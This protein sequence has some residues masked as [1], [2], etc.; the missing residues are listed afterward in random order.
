MNNTAFAIPLAYPDTVVMVS[1]EWCIRNLHYIGVGKRNYVK[2]GHAA[3]VLIE[4][5]TGYIEYFDFGRYITPQ[6]FGRV[7]SEYTDHELKTPIKAEIV[8]GVLM[9]RDA[10]FK[11]FATHPKLTHGEGRM[12]TT[13][14]DEVDYQ[15][16]KTY[17][18]KLQ[19]KGLVNYAAFKK[20]ASNCARFV[21]D[22]LMASTE[23][24]IKLKKLKG[25]KLFTPSPI[26]NVLAIKGDKGAY[27]VSIGGEIKLFNRTKQQEIVTCFLDKMSNHESTLKG[28]LESKSFEGLTKNAQW[29]PG[30]GAGAWFELFKTD[31][32][33]EYRFK[34]TSG[35][36][37]TDVDALFVI[38]DT[39]FRIDLPYTFTYNTNCSF[40]EIE[41]NKQLFKF[42]PLSNLKQKERSA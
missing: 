13:C 12:I 16:A 38:D 7:R 11:F 5:C 23:N 37:T 42:N 33:E 3:L 34:R 29:L 14:C 10:V 1:N 30:I 35:F 2:A 19:D 32:E 15:K 40:I 36:G 39:S 6:P 17:I 20:K 21:T 26:G 9:N 28:T 41:Q 4:K 27:Q 18:N 25:T 8:D 22:T 24:E 31:L